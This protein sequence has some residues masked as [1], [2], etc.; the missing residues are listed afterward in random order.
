MEHHDFVPNDEL[1]QIITHSEIQIALNKAKS[2][3]AM[4]IDKIPNE[5]LKN[6]NCEN[7]LLKLFNAYF[8]L[9]KIPSMWL[10]AIITPI[11]KSNSNDPR[12]PMSYRGISLLSTVSK[13]FTSI[14]NTRLRD[15][16]EKYNLLEDEQ[17]GFRKDRSCMDHVFTFTS[18]IRNHINQ[19]QGYFCCIHRFPQSF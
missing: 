18:I 16:L 10:K 7:I 4:G 8:D 2:N 13:L 15:Y 3:K 9:G 1:N 12:I 19:K 14:L 11:P 17:N 5:I 6:A